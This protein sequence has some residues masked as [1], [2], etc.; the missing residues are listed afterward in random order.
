MRDFTVRLMQVL[1]II[2]AVL[3]ALTACKP[4]PEKTTEVPAAVVVDHGQWRVPEDSPLRPRLTLA[5]VEEKEAPHAFLLPATV[6][7]NPAHVVNILPPLSGKVIDLKVGLG[8]HVVS[9]QVLAVISSGDLDQAYADDD[10]ARDALDLAKKTRDRE[11]ELKKAGTAAIKDTEAAESAY[12][13]ALFE[14]KRAEERLKSLGGSPGLKESDRQMTI[15]APTS[16]S[17]TSLSVAPGTYVNDVTA[18]IMVIANLDSVWVTANV[19]ENNVSAIAIGQQ[20]DISL[21]AYPEQVFH[22]IVS[23]I[24][25][26][27]EP[28]TRREKVRIAID[29]ADGKFKPNMFANVT[30]HLPQ[31]KAIFVPQSALLMNNDSVAVF[32]ETGDWVFERRMVELGDDENSE[33]RIL[34]GLAAGDKVIVK[35]GVLIND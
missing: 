20:V 1:A 27:L 23:S 6:E 2:A 5:S 28:D 29:N 19:P 15:T 9:G 18:A 33:V 10:K 3:S 30:F 25:A 34:K 13:Q 12:T 21:L 17:V 16:G 26:V 4:S 7:G 11:Q 24:N 32:V 22:G 8:D 31:P 35:G 14:F